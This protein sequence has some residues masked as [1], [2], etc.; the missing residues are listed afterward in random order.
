MNAKQICTCD[1][2]IDSLSRHPWK[3]AEGRVDRLTLKRQELSPG[4]E[5]SKGDSRTCMGVG[6]RFGVLEN[7]TELET[8]GLHAEKVRG[9]RK[10]DLKDVFK[11]L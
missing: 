8:Q 3:S 6:G 9:T 4:V 10:T 2:N 11:R 7:E 5:V 1:M